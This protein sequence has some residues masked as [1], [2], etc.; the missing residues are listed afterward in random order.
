M[1]CRFRILAPGSVEKAF[2]GYHY[3]RCMRLPK[4]SF[5]ALVQYR[6]E[7]HTDNYSNMNRVLIESLKDIQ[8]NPSTEGLDELVSSENFLQ[9]YQEITSVK[10]DKKFH[11][12]LQ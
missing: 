10:G 9:L 4:E 12:L 2:S 8:K 3:Y 11:F 5:D 6:A 1:V 7:Q